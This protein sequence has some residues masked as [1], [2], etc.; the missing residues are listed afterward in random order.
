MQSGTAMIPA[1][2]RFN[3]G[4]PGREARQDECSSPP[5]GSKVGQYGA[6]GKCDAIPCYD[7]FRTNDDPDR[8]WSTPTR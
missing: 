6:T 1:V 8:G 2:Q 4:T 7:V 3:D 5:L